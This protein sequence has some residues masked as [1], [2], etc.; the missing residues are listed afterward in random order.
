LNRFCEPGEEGE[1]EYNDDYSDEYERCKEMENNND[2][3]NK[4]KKDEK[5][6][7]INDNG[8]RKGGGGGKGGGVQ[9]MNVREKKREVKEVR[10]KISGMGMDGGSGIIDLS[11]NDPIIAMLV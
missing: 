4:W 1:E 5:K 11:E 9:K 8:K 3:D 7:A 6:S 10:R 2:N